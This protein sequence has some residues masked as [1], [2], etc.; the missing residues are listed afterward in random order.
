MIFATGSTFSQGT[1][2]PDWMAPVMGGRD[3]SGHHRRDR[4]RHLRH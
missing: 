1:P 2:T 4:R 3:R